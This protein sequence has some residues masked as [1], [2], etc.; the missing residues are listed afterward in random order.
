MALAVD[1][2]PAALKEIR[3]AE[4]EDARRR[5]VAAIDRLADDPMPKDSVLLEGGLGLRRIR[6][7]DWRIVYR[8]DATARRVT[9][10]IVAHRREVYR[11]L[12]RRLRR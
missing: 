9:V 4:P 3:R 10:V 11:R 2:L 6:V 1:I 8:L 5:L 7:G 12:S